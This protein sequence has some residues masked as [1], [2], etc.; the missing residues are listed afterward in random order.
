MIPDLS[1]HVLE[2]EGM[3][4]SLLREADQNEFKVL[5][6]SLT[7]ATGK[8]DLLRNLKAGFPLPD[9]MGVNWDAL[10]E[11]LRDLPL[12]DHKGFLLVLRGADGLLS[13]RLPDL[14]TL[15]AILTEAAKFWLARDA[16]F[17]T[18]L[19]GSAALTEALTSEILRR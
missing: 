5:Q 8:A 19:V 2:D 4:A 1:V 7:G 10:E 15:I 14:R 3:L 6:L 13:L 16:P 17:S 18:V 12:G 11:C 9:Y